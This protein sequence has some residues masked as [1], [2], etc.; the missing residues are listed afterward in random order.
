MS[1]D[2]YSLCPGGTG[3]K[4][5]F[6]P[7]C[8]DIL[9][10]LGKLQEQVQSGQIAAAFENARALDARYPDRASL[11]S[12]KT[13]LGWANKQTASV[14]ESTARF[15]EKYPQNP[16]ALAF[17]AMQLVREGQLIPALNTLQDSLEIVETDL[18]E[19]VYNAMQLISQALL[20]QGHILPA[21]GLLTLCMVI[22]KAQDQS[23]MQML[24]QLEGSP[25]V[26]VLLKDV[27]GYL[28]GKKDAPYRAD[29]DNALRFAGRGCWRRGVQI[30]EGL[31]AKNPEDPAIWRNLAVARG[32]MGDYRASADA[33][34]KYAELD[35]E[36][37]DEIE[38]EATA[39]LLRRDEAEGHVDD[40]MVRVG[41]NDYEKL[42]QSLL[43]NRR[44]EKLTVDM[45]QYADEGQPPPRAIFAIYN[46]E[47]LDSAENLRCTDI[48]VIIAHAYLF[49]KETDRAA[50]VELDVYRTNLDATVSALR[51][52]GGDAI[53][54]IE[55]EEIT[56]KVSTIELATSWQWRLPENT[57]MK[58][59][60]RLVRDQREHVLIEVWP[61]LKLPLLDNM[62]PAE[63]SADWHQRD[64]L[65]AAIMLLEVT[66]ASEHA[67]VIFAK[68]REKLGLPLPEI[69]DPA[70]F[71]YKRARLPRFLYMPL[72]KLTDEQLRLCYERVMVSQFM[73][74]GRRLAK[75]V[76]RRDSMKDQLDLRISA[77]QVMI[78]VT[79]EPD[80][81][82][83]YVDEARKL[84]EAH[85]ES[86]APW[87]LE[88]LALRIARREANHV[89]RLVQHISQAHIRE[90]GIADALFNI[91]R[92]AGLVGPNGEMMMP[93]PGA[94][95]MG[96]SINTAD[97]DAASQQS[98]LWTP[99][100]DSGQ[101]G[102]K[103]SSLWVPE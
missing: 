30:W 60:M 62:T 81:A 82:I 58:E 10:E 102:G 56:G 37:D 44:S 72:D 91:L 47:R 92:S 94:P 32:Y 74:A 49:G 98:K 68:L 101:S 43:A 17:Q 80:E 35:V 26:P 20:S 50:R 45:K 33:W 52:I 53:G 28:E 103:K 99:D 13:L 42:E 31:L 85:K 41:I 77:Y 16:V 88:E 21:R 4:V 14:A 87:D 15:L 5:K 39:Q 40:L 69:E 83:R 65:Q 27:P 9:N 46:R 66:D 54:G 89:T 90:E 64:R 11:L 71:D 38:A 51:E 61:T 22:S 100:G 7:C 57:D 70:T 34:R 95:G 73:A 19:T 93:A 12:Y 25:N 23:I 76:L 1:L 97:V 55:N 59:R 84:A 96:G 2:P 67:P 24:M 6:C 36:A 48:P 78:R 79:E 18:P 8:Q 63:A 3:K 86:T 75:E 29:F